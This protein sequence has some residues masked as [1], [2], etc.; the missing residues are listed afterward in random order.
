MTW[1]DIIIILVATALHMVEVRLAKQIT[2]NCPLYCAVDH[3][4][5]CPATKGAGL[6]LESC[7]KQE[8]VERW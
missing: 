7:F 6:D 4:H 3:T 1:A 8:C 2:Y 5:F